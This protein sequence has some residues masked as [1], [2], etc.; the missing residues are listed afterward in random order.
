VGNSNVTLQD[1]VDGVATIGDLTPVLI[2]TGGYA[3]E[4]ALT[5]ANDVLSEMFAERYPW[6]WNR[7]KIPPFLLFP[8][9]QDYASINVLNIG[10]LEN[11]F[12]IDVNNTQVPPYTEP[13]TVVR[14]LA[15]STVYS[16]WPE[17]ACWFPNNQLEQW[18]WPGPGIT[19]YNPVGVPQTPA[20]SIT[21]ILD[22]NGNIL[23]LT[24]YGTTGLIE[25]V[26]V[27]PPLDPLDPLGP[28]DYD[29]D[30]TG[31]V[32][33][34]GTAQWTV[35][36]PSAAGIRVRPAPADGA[37]T[38]LMRLF[39]QKKAPIIKTLDDKLDPIPDDQI[40]WFRDGFICYAHRHSANPAVRARYPL[41]KTD[42]QNS[43][44]AETRQ[45]DRETE[46]KGFYPAR[47]LMAPGR[48]ADLGPGNPYMRS[49]GR[50]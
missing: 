19:F 5:I 42:W 11:G 15:V 43:M 38:W 45:A 30:L 12:R 1:V 36:N 25:P 39:A 24:K 46:S 20:N 41:M 9:Q 47:S 34:D 27:Y 26:A 7:M 35:V 21:N 16:G 14:D 10:W 40:K 29:A 23:I 18:I 31:Q 33:D 50:R 4:P 28:K 44:A 17:E 37:N 32:I 6:K 3:A 13:V 22:P 8:R 2:N 48:F 49:G